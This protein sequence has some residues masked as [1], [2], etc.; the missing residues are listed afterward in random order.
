[1]PEWAG[2]A[3]PRENLVST[4]AL[5]R[6]VGFL[7][8]RYESSFEISWGCFQSPRRLSRRSSEALVALIPLAPF[9]IL[10]DKFVF[11]VGSPGRAEIIPSS[12]III[13]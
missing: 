11:V 7:R 5:G 2:G 8:A 6:G 13:L 1:M 10:A 4:R 3:R 9:R 12:V